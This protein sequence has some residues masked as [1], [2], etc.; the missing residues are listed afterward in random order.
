MKD[1][2]LDV[3][4]Y[5]FDNYLDDETEIQPDRDI[6]RI[7]LEGAGFDRSEVVKAFDWLEVIATDHSSSLGRH[8]R[9]AMRIYHPEELLRLSAESRGFLMYLENSGILN[10][11]QRELV[12]DRVMALDSGE[13]DLDQLK[14][15]ILMVLF[16]QPGQEAAYAHMEELVCEERPSATH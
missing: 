6:L 11:E 13:I 12:I 4:M 7:E 10:P 1:T 14:W 3:L 5:L 8:D 2:V 15:I 16:N 9:S